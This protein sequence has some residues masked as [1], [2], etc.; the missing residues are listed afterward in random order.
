MPDHPVN[1]AIN[2]LSG[3]FWGRNPHEELRWMRQ[4]APVYYDENSGVWGISKYADLKMISRTPQ[5][6]SNAHGI[7]PD[8]P[9]MAMMID[10]DDPAHKL[11]RKLVSAG[12]TRRRVAAQEGYLRRVCDEIIDGVC[13]RGECD[14]VADIAAQLPLIVIGD[15]L[16]FAP[17]DR[18][19]LLKWS[20][21]MVRALTGGDDPRLLTDA[22]EAFAGFTEYAARAIEQ[23]RTDPR[24][25][26]LSVLVHAEV[27]GE[28][29]DRDSL[30][31]EAL[32]ILIGGD[33]TTRHVISGGMYQ[34]C[35][36]PD[37]RRKLLDDP[38]KIPAAVEE[39]CRWVSP[40]KNMNR[41]ATRDF[42]LRG[43]L[44]REGDK[45]L[46][47]YPS[48][49]RD[50]EVFDDPFRF[51]IERSPNDHIAFGNGP[52]FC[53][54]NSLARLEMKVMFEQLLAR[55]PDIEPVEEGEPPHRPAN[56]V[57]GYETFKVRF[58]PSP[59]MAA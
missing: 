37:Q 4:N 38:G 16:G 3:E 26:L 8:A 48:A 41:T 31:H 35:I 24:D 5:V 34:L 9:A 20:D 18:P 19:L 29:L 33:E 32:L 40:V 6:F 50:E 42:E 44:I 23:R 56:F 59:R 39:M 1:D 7:R 57:S 28:R 46:L 45:V 21:D 51:D 17:E 36:H 55:L 47:L 43:Q 11:R 53:L 15:A 52:H 14:F 25:D 22:A 27:D 30:V 13:E 49:N 12:F 58:T 54:G 10:M 2:L